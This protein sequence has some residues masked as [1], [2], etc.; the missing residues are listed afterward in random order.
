MISIVNKGPTGSRT[1]PDECKY[2][3]IVDGDT[4]A[5][6]HHSRQDGVGV[7]LRIAADAVDGIENFTRN[8]PIEGEVYHH[9]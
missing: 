8:L 5:L 3:V 7:C 6:F 9:E 1:R 2:A 4:I